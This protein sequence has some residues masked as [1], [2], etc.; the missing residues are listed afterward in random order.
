MKFLSIILIFLFFNSGCADSSAIAII[1]LKKVASESEAGKDIEKQIEKLNEEAKNDLQ[2]LEGKIKSMESNK[3][4]SD[5]DVRKIEDMQLILYD[6]V[7]TK[8]YHISEAYDKAIV[9]L[10]QKMK[11]IIEEICQKESIEITLNSDAV[12]YFG[13]NPKDITDRVIA[14]LNEVCKSIK[15]ELRKAG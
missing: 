8:K 2:D 4:S 7:R 13:K 1:D 12:V 11:K 9:A 14:R 5:Y 10:D 3:K 6:M 15:V